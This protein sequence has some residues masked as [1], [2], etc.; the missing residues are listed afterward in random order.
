MRELRDPDAVVYAT[1]GAL[2]VL[3]FAVGMAALAWGDP[4]GFDL[5]D[6]TWFV[7][8][9]GVFMAIYFVSMSLS[10]LAPDE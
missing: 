5:G 10:H 7:A 1:S 2:A 3:V 9:F 6:A 4:S 8:G